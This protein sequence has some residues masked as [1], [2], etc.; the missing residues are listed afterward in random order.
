MARRSPALFGLL[1]LSAIG[2]TGPP[3]EVVIE[4]RVGEV[5]AR[6]DL[7]AAR[8]TTAALAEVGAQWW[9]QRDQRRAAADSSSAE[10]RGE[11]SASVPEAIAYDPVPPQESS[12][13]AAQVHALRE[14]PLDEAAMLTRNLAEA[15][16]KLW[17]EIGPMLL[18]D[19]D[20]PKREY[21]QVLALIGGDVPNRYGHFALH[22][23][24]AHGY[25]VR[26]SEDWFEDLLGLAHARVSKPLH[27][28]YRDALLTVAL[29]RA[30]SKAAREDPKLVAD[31][32]ATLLDS[33]YVLD[34]T[35]RDEVG[36]AIDAIGDPAIPPLLRES[37]APEGADEASTAAR[38][39]AYAT[40]CLDRMDRL[41]PSRAIEAVSHERLLLADVLQAYAIVR[42]GEAAPLLLD[43]I[44][45]DAPGVRRAARAAFESYVT[46]PLPS[47]RRKSI[48]L[49]GGRT[50]TQRAELSYREH[51]RLAI[52]Q[53]LQTTAPDLLE[54]EC[55]LRLAGGLVDAQC[56][57][58]PERLFR[59]YVSLLDQRRMAR[60]D[61]TVARALSSDDHIAGAA[62]LD[63]LLSDG[64]DPVDP[65][66]I[67]PFYSEVAAEIEASGDPA[68]A[69]QLLRKSAM[70]LA[71]ADPDRAR[72]LSVDA[73]VLEARVE[74]VDERGR[75]MLL[76]TARDLAPDEPT[77]SAAL[78]QLEAQIDESSSGTRGRL[79]VYLLALLACLTL[80][81]WVGA[82][83][84]RPREPARQP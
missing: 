45:A 6:S 75:M 58:Q 81:A 59:A 84:H 52:R 53:R 62:M 46:G 82:L 83:L 7:E 43:H 48:R 79:R 8:E 31:V 68:R 26:V 40:Y 70:L 1:V 33:G 2:C 37:V 65:D 78:G 4:T 9:A 21:K 27:P 54:P 61:A 50:S 41:H 36:R 10:I 42:D 72:E 30:A 55:E 44:D 5:Q 29:L 51:A 24:K 11:V 3:A 28:V 19:R 39:A 12:S 80:L 14:G 22:W 20:R 56:E 47:V 18:A 64:S 69:A 17:P 23:K 34:G 32:V 15:G 49:L 25:D 63:T 67:A 13:F 74:G 60:R 73:L 57:G 71:D 76:G 66:L 77:V 38:R 35:F 16:A